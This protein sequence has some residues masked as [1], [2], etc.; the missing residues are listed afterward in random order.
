MRSSIIITG[1]SVMLLLASSFLW[2]Q[3]K[4]APK[5]PVSKII[6]LD[7]KGADY[8]PILTGPPE[9]ATMHSG[10][11]TLKPGKN[12]GK[13][14]TKNNEEIV[15]ALSGHGEMRISGG[16][17]LAFGKG[18]AVYCPARLEHDVYN[19]G[20]EDFQYVYVVARAVDGKS[21]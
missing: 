19:T 7:A 18:E 17:T 8:M 15:I 20:S 6:T 11:V 1:A 3:E 13:H 16:D 2:S 12:V 4:S 10:L 5:H 14:S 9:T 21:K